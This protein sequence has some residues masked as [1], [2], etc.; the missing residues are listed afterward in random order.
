MG[1]IKAATIAITVGLLGTPALSIKP[2]EAEPWPQRTVTFVTP[3][4]VG[5]AT[6]LASRLFANALAERWGK[7]VIVE[8][9]PGGDMITGMTAFARMNNDHVLLFSNSSPIAVHPVTYEKLPYD[10][11]RDFLPISLASDIF[12]AIA[13]SESLKVGSVGDLIKLARAQSGK[14]NW[15]SAP[16]IGQYVF[17]AF[18]R[19]AALGMTLVPYR[20]LT[21]ALQDLSEG[22]IHVMQHSLSAL[23]PL[24]QARKA[25]LLVVNNSQRAAIA[26]DVPTAVE[27]GYSELAFDGFCGLFAGRG[28]PSELRE[29]IAA[30]VR[31]VAGDPLVG[32]RL[33]SAGQVA[34]GSTPAE[35]SAA[36]EQLRAAATAMVRTIGITPIQ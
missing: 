24:V 18:E 16:G 4:A 35:F 34:R 29:R 14:I 15:A 13:V 5:T 21:P 9:R 22:R 19:R 11:L 26:P 17:A 31:A 33:A 2:S 6:D 10:P 25:R 3:M 12:V 23:M 20:E 36:L 30:D 8:N 27:A 1:A 28:M 32:E 7:P